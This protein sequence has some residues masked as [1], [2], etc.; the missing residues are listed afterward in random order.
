MMVG[1][2]ITDM[3]PKED[4]DIGE[5]VLKVENLTCHIAK[6]ISFEVKRGEVLGLFG[7]VGS[8]RVEAVEGL[9]GIKAIESGKFTFEGKQ[10]NIDNPI[11]AKGLGIGYI[12][13]DR[14]QDGLVLVNTVKNNLTVTVLDEVSKMGIL[15]AKAENDCCN[16]WIDKLGIKTPSGHVE[17][18]SLSGGN[19]QKLLSQSG[20]SL[21]QR[22]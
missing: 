15:N 19:Q 7:L 20:Y 13:S 5:S 16:T 22:Y 6:D 21:I 1:R 12:P 11:V 18:D 14:K 9:L 8:G 17:V 2:E 10:V 3:Y 4:N